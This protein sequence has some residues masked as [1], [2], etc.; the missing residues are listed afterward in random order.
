MTWVSSIRI[1]WIVSVFMPTP[2]GAAT[3][4]VS[5]KYKAGSRADQKA[6]SYSEDR[7]GAK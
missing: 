5:G 1:V 3:Y 4:I 2:R 7:D 6:K